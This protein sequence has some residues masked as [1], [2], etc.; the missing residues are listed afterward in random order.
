M[1]QKKSLYCFE[2]G[3]TTPHSYIGSKS[4]YEGTGLARI[5]IA[6]ASFGMSETSWADKYWQCEVC[7]NIKRHG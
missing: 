4:M 6:A 7:G 5:S 3:K 2:C 1:L